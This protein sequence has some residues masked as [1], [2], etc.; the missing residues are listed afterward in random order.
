MIALQGLSTDISDQD[1]VE[2]MGMPQELAFKPEMNL[3][4]T[5]Y[6]YLR[7]KELETPEETQRLLVEQ[8]MQMR[9]IISPRIWVDMDVYPE[10][11]LISQEFF[12]EDWWMDD[13]DLLEAC[14]KTY[15][16]HE[17]KPENR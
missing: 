7:N 15:Y 16:R 1:F 5:Y 6:V 11:K 13:S 10:R 4:M 2:E 9:I 17:T 12:D 14:R 3:W 8:F